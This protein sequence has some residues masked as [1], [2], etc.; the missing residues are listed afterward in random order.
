[1]TDIPTLAIIAYLAPRAGQQFK[2]G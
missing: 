2:I 1:M